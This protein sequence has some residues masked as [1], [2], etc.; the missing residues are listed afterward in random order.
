MKN[1]VPGLFA[2]ALV[3]TPAQA[4]S[5]DKAGMKKLGLKFLDEVK[6]CKKADKVRHSVLLADGK[7]SLMLV[8]KGMVYRVVFDE[9]PVFF[10]VES[11]ALELPNSTLNFTRVSEEEVQLDSVEALLDGFR[12]DSCQA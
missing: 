3:A 5:L 1:V 11:Y 9:E 2:A 7:T 4:E 12:K 8:V 6:A 10:G